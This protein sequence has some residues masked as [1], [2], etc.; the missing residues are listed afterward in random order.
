[1]KKSKAKK[2]NELPPG[3]PTDALTS[4]SVLNQTINH[5][6]LPIPTIFQRADFISRYSSCATNSVSTALMLSRKFLLFVL[7]LN[8][9][10][11]LQMIDINHSRLPY[12][13]T[14]CH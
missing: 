2:T 6:V 4:G 8:S 11:L 12:S 1:M 13:M 3:S 14:C 5:E 7:K 10:H 9:L